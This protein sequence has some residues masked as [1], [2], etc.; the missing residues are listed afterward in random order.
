MPASSSVPP[1]ASIVLPAKLVDALSFKFSVPVT[2]RFPP[3]LSVPVPPIS[4]SPFAPT[5]PPV[6]FKVPPLTSM[7][8]LARF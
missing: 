5:L 7:L 3:R 8:L 1:E 2:A 6:I 4:S